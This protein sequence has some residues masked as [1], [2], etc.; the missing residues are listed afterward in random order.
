MNKATIE[1][2]KLTHAIDKNQV[3]PF[4]IL[5]DAKMEGTNA[6]YKVELMGGNTVGCPGESQSVK[7]LW[8]SV[9]AHASLSY[10]RTFFYLK[11]LFK[12]SLVIL[13]KRLYIALF[14]RSDK[15]YAVS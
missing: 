12:K 2:V 7:T 1:S 14:Y 8:C 3:Y 6:V 10:L 11:T 5:G 9:S 4:R 15:M 13:A